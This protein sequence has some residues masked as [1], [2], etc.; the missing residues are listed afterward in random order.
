MASSLVFLS[1]HFGTLESGILASLDISAKD[2]T[3]N[4]VDKLVFFLSNA[5][6]V[7]KFLDA[8]ASLAPTHVSPSVRPSVRR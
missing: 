5:L 8:Q 2:Q 3:L 6:Q 4:K 7:S 1:F